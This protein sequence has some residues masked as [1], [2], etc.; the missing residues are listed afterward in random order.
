[1]ARRHRNRNFG[2]DLSSQLVIKSEGL[3]KEILHP[4]FAVLLKSIG[5]FLNT[6][7]ESSTVLTPL[8]LSVKL[9]LYL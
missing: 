3:G 5:I 8:D 9:Q 2:T 1:M 6:E 7:V 4:S